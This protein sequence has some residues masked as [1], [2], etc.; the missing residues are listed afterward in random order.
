MLLNKWVEKKKKDDKLEMLKQKDKP[1][2]YEEREKQ[3]RQ[4][5]IMLSKQNNKNLNHNIPNKKTKSKRRS[6]RKKT[7]DVQ[8]DAIPPSTKDLKSEDS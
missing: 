1:I 3:W 2:T 4:K 7:I 5:N 6:S 8:K